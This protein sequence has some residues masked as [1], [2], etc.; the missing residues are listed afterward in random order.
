VRTH[1]IMRFWDLTLRHVIEGEHAKA[2]V[3]SDSGFGLTEGL[4]QDIISANRSVSSIA[5]DQFK[6]LAMW[7]ISRD[8]E[9]G[10]TTWPACENSISARTELPAMTPGDEAHWMAARGLW[11]V[12]DLASQCHLG[13]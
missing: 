12:Y 5:C 7:C 11:L 4:F 9:V 13:T 8:F 6:E 1:R 10:G 3:A 2:T